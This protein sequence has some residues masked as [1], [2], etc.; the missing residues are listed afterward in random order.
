MRKQNRS[1]QQAG[2]AAKYPQAKHGKTAIRKLTAGDDLGFLFSQDPE[3]STPHSFA[4]ALATAIPATTLAEILTEK[5][6]LPT[7]AQSLQAAIRNS[8]PPQDRLDLHGCT[9]PEAEIKTKNFLTRARRNHLKTVLIITGKGLHSP[10]GSVLKDVIETRLKIMKT[11]GSILAY[12]WEKK[13]RE[14][15]G[16]LLVYLP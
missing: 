11:D 13:D 16:A 2:T 10:E 1:P 8:P 5:E 3:D 15:S 7:P 6:E 9:G 4:G 14:K 12:L